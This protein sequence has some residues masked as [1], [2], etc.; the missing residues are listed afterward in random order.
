[1]GFT[2]A[3]DHKERERREKSHGIEKQEESPDL[4]AK[5]MCPGGCP[6]GLRAA[7]MEHSKQYVVI[8]SYQWE[9]NS[10]E[11]KQLVWPA[12]VLHKACL[13]T[14]AVCFSSANVND[15]WQEGTLHQGFFLIILYNMTIPLSPQS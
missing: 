1:M 6:I 3:W 7:K 13:N 15:H 2:L 12:S 14:E 5:R 11:G 8:W 4:W 9:S 10:W